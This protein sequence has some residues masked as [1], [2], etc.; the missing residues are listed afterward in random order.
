MTTLVITF[1]IGTLGSLCSL[2]VSY[3]EHSLRGLTYVGNKQKKRI[4]SNTISFSDS[5]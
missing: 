4:L 1:S 2:E 3:V 5:I